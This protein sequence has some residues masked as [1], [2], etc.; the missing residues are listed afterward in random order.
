MVMDYSE[1]KF[2]VDD[3]IAIV[4]L[5]NPDKLNAMTDAAK[6]EL[7]SAILKIRDDAAIK[8]MVITGTGRAFC[9]GGDINSQA[10]VKDIVGNR[11]RIKDLH[12]WITQLVNLEKPVIAAVNGLAVGAGCNL[13]FACDIIYAS[14]KAKFSEIFCNIG[15]IPD[16]GGLY[17]LPWAVG[18]FRAK[19]IVFTGRMVEAAEAFQIGL[20]NKIVAPEKLMEETMIIARK[21]AKGPS[22][23]YGVAKTLINKSYSWDLATLLEVEADAQAICARTEDAFEG[24]TAFLEKRKP[25]FKGR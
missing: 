25:V 2:E 11:E 7:E 5:N 19:E 8:V 16:A 13:A 21:L 20:V 6:I 10:R 3:G 14:E 1:I 4:T 18:P 9:A 15:L 23:A 22:I 24:R 12:R 17:F